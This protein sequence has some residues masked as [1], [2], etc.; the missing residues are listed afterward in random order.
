[1]RFSNKVVL[2]TGAGSGMGRATALAFAKEGAKV[3]VNDLVSKRGEETLAM[4]KQQGAEGIF[5]QS[6]VT[7]ATEVE[8]MVNEALEAYGRIDILINNAGVIVPGAVDTLTEAD[9]DKAFNVNVKGVFLVSKYVIPAMKRAGSGVVVNMGSVAAFKGY[10]DRSVY[11]AS[12]GAIVSL[13]KA[14]AMDYIK[15][16]IRVNCVCPGTIYTPA[17]EERIQDS[18]DPE[19]TKKALIARQPLGR[20]GTDEEIAHAI[21]YAA[22]PEAAYMIGSAL[23]IDGGATL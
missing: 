4:I 21:L 6:N 12:K 1:M 15:E 19:T 13:T 8:T 2:I 10:A 11:C 20:L 3:I 22:S 9:F 14:M 17:L 23:I 7:Q 16:N 5:L 18:D